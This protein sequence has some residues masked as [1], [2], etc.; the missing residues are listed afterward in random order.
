MDNVASLVSEISHSFVHQ[1]YQITIFLDL[2]KAYDTCWKYHILQELK[3]FNMQGNLPIFVKFFLENRTVHVNIG[4]ETSDN[5]PLDMGIP[6]GS[7]LSGTLF[8]IAINSVLSKLSSQVYKSLFVDDCRISVS[9][10]DLQSAKTNLQFALNQLQNWCCKT[11][12]SFSAKKSKV[13]I[14]HKKCRTIEPKKRFIS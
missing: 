12:F 11:G 3:K 13:L 5:F 9:A 6:Q 10:Y 1:K 14:C 8:L 7:A 4:K 2:E